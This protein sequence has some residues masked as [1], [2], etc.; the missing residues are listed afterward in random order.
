MMDARAD[1]VVGYQP[2]S[3]AD[4]FGGF[5]VAEAI[6]PRH[7][8]CHL[9]LKDSL[10]D[11]AEALASSGRTAMGIV[12]DKDS[13]VGMATVNDVMRAY[14]EGVPAARGL[15][16]WLASG[17]ARAPQRLLRRLEVKPT[18]LLA[19]VAAKMVANAVAGDC[20][21]HHILVKDEDG[22][23]HGV[24]SSHDLVR[25]FCHR[26]TWKQHPLFPD[27][28]LP[29]DA[30]EEVA[31]AMVQDIMKPRSR[32]FTCEPSDTMRVALKTLL[33]TQQNC[34]I[35]VDDDAGICGLVTPRDI[36]KAFADVIDLEMSVA[37]WMKSRPSH[38]E[39][40]TIPGETR[41]MD[42]AE[43]MTK[44]EVDHLV[45]VTQE[46]SEALGIL[47]SLDVVLQSKARELVL[48]V[49]VWQGPS[50]GDALR[51]HSSHA[52]CTKATPLGRICARLVDADQTS[53]IVQVNEAYEVFGLLTESDLVRAFINGHGQTT[54]LGDILPNPECRHKVVPVYLQVTPT[55]HLVE[56]GAIML[57][58]TEP[59]R[60]C[61]HLAVRAVTGGWL[62][63][64]SALD[65][66]RALHNL[67]TQLDLAKAG[68]DNLTVEAIMKPT[69]IIPT[70]HP[71]EPIKDAL[72]KLD[73]FSQSAVMIVEGDQVFGLI[74]PRCAVEA[75][76]RGVLPDTTVED[77]LKTRRI[78]EGPR[79]VLRDASVK[80]AADIMTKHALHHLLVV[81]EPGSKPVGVL[82]A[83]D[84]VRS[85]VSTHHRFPF[86]T[87]GWLR[88]LG[89]PA[90]FAERPTP[91]KRV[92][93]VAAEGE[94]VTKS[95]KA[96]E[97]GA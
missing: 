35:V 75:I 30:R 52:L 6:H 54:P 39:H 92:A 7:F 23:L 93:D 28:F 64:F 16:E 51:Q 86:L 66:A 14:F 76:A 62:G 40:K 42:A 85:L 47:S 57:S 83:L 19:E 38:M 18:A 41:V 44:F 24:V 1:V 73:V 77:W 26:D 91:T 5:T 36:V 68:L 27:L 29:T 22:R 89:V 78:P 13:V 17:E 84:L 12:D 8:S 81:R 37:E 97:C 61:H 72:S 15:V 49:P 53:I 34:V 67:S 90:S 9:K 59:G 63:V 80:Q 96:E 71:S 25:A 74:T 55:A 31:N 11:L 48:P 94:P 50:V 4:V 87:L 95:R 20:A 70:C 33:V 82:S 21:C 60:A 2:K 65:V 58:S 56:A 69:D 46:G 10:S 88:Q 79:E 43:A 45:V 3:G 32:V